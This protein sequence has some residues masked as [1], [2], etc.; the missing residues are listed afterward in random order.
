[1][2]IHK[3]PVTFDWQSTHGL[4]PL[5]GKWP[6]SYQV[7]PVTRLIGFPDFHRCFPQLF[8]RYLIE[9]EGVGLAVGDVDG[10]RHYMMRRNKVSLREGSSPVLGHLAGNELMSNL[11]ALSLSWLQQWSVPFAVISG[12]GGDEV[13]LVATGLKRDEFARAVRSLSRLLSQDLPCSVSFAYGWFTCLEQEDAIQT[14][15]DHYYINSLSLVDHA[16]FQYKAKVGTRPHVVRLATR[17][18]TPRGWSLAASDCT[19]RS[20]AFSGK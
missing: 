20:F 10:M 8:Q 17:Y 11:G 13:I 12:F 5:K 16:L 18:L 1:L 4:A 19:T 15:F 6:E 7:D 2:I 3:Q 9:N 14:S